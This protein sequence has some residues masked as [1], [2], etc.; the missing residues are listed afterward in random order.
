MYREF[1]C[2]LRLT[3]IEQDH[4]NHRKETGQMRDIAPVLSAGKRIR[5]QRD[6]SAGTAAT[7]IGAHFA[8]HLF[9]QIFESAKWV[10]K[11]AE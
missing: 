8:Q 5:S 2:D 7:A 10:S 9:L 4:S 1:N 6:Q 3:V 11:E